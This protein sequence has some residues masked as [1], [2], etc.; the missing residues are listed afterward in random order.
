MICFSNF[1]KILILLT[2]FVLSILVQATSNAEELSQFYRNNILGVTLAYDPDYSIVEPEY[3][4]NTYGFTL[5]DQHRNPILDVDWLYASNSSDFINVVDLKL[6]NASNLS[7]RQESFTVDGYS[8]IK[9]SPMPGITR[10]TEIVIIANERIFVIRYYDDDLGKKGED[11]I[12]KLSFEQPSEQFHPESMTHAEDV[13]FVHP[14]SDWHG[15]RYV[16][17]SQLE[18]VPTPELVPESTLNTKSSLF[19]AEGIN[20]EPS[21]IE[22]GCTTDWS[23]NQTNWNSWA[24]QGTSHVGISYAG[25]HFWGAGGHG[26][27]N[28]SG[29]YNDYY[30]LDHTLKE[31]DLIYPHRSGTIIYSGWTDGGW[32]TLGRIVVVDY[33]Y[34]RWGVFA[35]L[36]GVIYPTGTWVSP[37]H[38]IGYAG[39]SGDH[40]ENYWNV[41]LHQSLHLNAQFHYESGNVI[42]IK[43]G[44]SARPY[45]IQ[46]YAN[47]YYYYNMSSGMQLEWRPGG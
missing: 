47:T 32:K 22:P 44:Q 12:Q 11:I 5:V 42:G 26:G 14:P 30:A 40:R 21:A 24:N 17:K 3:L 15:W 18:A 27:C 34:G 41:H 36:R 28:D 7:T 9:I 10:S 25:P 2:I 13:V 4:G 46:S 19:L 23:S 38:A 35:H 20:P 6:T 8:G 29:S 31:W 43:G 39:G 16:D 1:R 45:Y 33:G 37:A